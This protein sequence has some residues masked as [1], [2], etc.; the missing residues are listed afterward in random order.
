MESETHINPW[1]VSNVEEFLYF[2]CPECEEREKSKK[3]SSQQGNC[4][5]TLQ[6]GRLG[7]TKPYSILELPQTRMAI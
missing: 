6:Q 4:R 3:G 1:L 2:C 5:A 7:H